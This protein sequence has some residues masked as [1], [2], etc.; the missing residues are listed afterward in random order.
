MQILSSNFVG[1]IAQITKNLS[2]PRRCI[3]K[4]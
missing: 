1:R 2:K 4:F 3:D